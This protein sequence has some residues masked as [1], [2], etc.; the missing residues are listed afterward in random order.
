MKE[1]QG[2]R[3]TD[4]KKGKAKM[5]SISVWSL[6]AAVFFIIT[7]ASWA[8][9]S[10]VDR[11]LQLL[12][13]KGVV[14]EQEAAEFRADLAV[15]KQEEK[16]AQKEFTLL[17]ARPMKMSGYTQV[18]YRKDKTIKDTFDIRRARLDIK[19][20]ITER[21]DYQMQV[22]FG[23]TGGPFL[24]DAIGAYRVNPYM[25]ISFGQQKI[26]FSQEN[27]AGDQKMET[28][29][30]SQVVE[31]MV[32]RGRDVIGNQNGRDIGVQA[33]GSILPKDDYYRIDYAL[34]VFN[35]SGINRADRNEQKDFAGRLVFH[36][37][38]DL[39]LGASYYNGCGNW[40]I[41]P[42]TTLFNHDRDRYG[43]EFAYAH[44]RV[45]VKGEYI[46]GNDGVIKRDGW[47]L[48]TA[49]FLIPN[50]LQAVF[51]FDTYDPD[52]KINKDEADVYTLGT[53]WYFN[54][55]AFFQLN[56]ELKDE[57]GNEI[58]NDALSGQ[59]TLQF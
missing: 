9:E 1:R 6:S 36:P 26:P 43:G 14:T 4:T 11:L 3:G 15:K 58:Q 53:S 47:Y 54:K 37:I 55:W 31:A 41:A 50:K 52:R 49:Y 19:G 33:A 51:K 18:R 24:L 21:F 20:D 13:K 32:A 40:A 17:A 27:L 45:S 34:G 59:F 46:R 2:G 10:D 5:R 28:I 7:S 35:G 8:V 42:S 56:Y 16:E 44:E 57:H 22:E 30:R 38:K 12:V 23:G 25:R 29:N 39:S 48:Q